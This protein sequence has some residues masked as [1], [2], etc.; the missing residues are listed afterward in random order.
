M[1][2]AWEGLRVIIALRP[3]ALDRLADVRIE[4]RGI[5]LDRRRLGVAGMLFGVRAGVFRCS[6]NVGELLRSETRTTAGRVSSRVRSSLIVAEV[7]LSFA[8]LVGSGLLVRSF[9][10]LSVRTSAS[11]RTISSRWI[12]SRDQR[13]LGPASG[14]P[15]ASRSREPGRDTW[16]RVGRRRNAAN[17][18]LSKHGRHSHGRRP[19]RRDHV[20]QVAAHGDVD[21]LEL[22]RS[23]RH[24]ARRRT[25][26]RV[27]AHPTSR[28]RGRCRA[29][30]TAGCRKRSSSVA[31]WRGASPRMGT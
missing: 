11:S 15:R 10:A 28:L 14:K 21:R 13:S 2:V 31:H 29:W 18:R 5:V 26:C 7:A 3:L 24:R 22:F 9:M 6:Q 1:L 25:R 8:L 4:L 16:R 23:E 27:P 19:G 17:S 20:A 12:F 30:R